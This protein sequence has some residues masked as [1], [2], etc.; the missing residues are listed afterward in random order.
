[1]YTTNVIENLNKIFR[2]A[3]KI[4]NNFLTDM[5]LMKILYLYAIN[6]TEKWKLGYVREWYLIKGQLVIEHEERGCY[7]LM[8]FNH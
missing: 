4:R 2:K 8:I 7:K 6:L 5:V 3:I 1:M